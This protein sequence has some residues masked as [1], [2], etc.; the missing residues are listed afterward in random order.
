MFNQRQDL[1]YSPPLTTL[2]LGAGFGPADG[3][4][5]VDIEARNITNALSQD[6][7]S[8]PPDPR[9]AAFYGAYAASPNR[10]R[11][12]MLSASIRY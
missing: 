8:A 7:A 6:F 5:S 1:Y 10:L 12:V 9:F 2:D 3:R 4:W 11:T